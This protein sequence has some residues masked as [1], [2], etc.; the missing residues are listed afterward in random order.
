M[1]IYVWL[2]I[3]GDAVYRAEKGS[4]SGAWGIGPTA[5][6][7]RQKVAGAD[8]G[9]GDGA[10]QAFSFLPPIQSQIPDPGTGYPLLALASPYSVKPLWR[11]P[12]RQVQ[13]SVS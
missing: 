6:T 12:H 7:H 1:R 13:K 10:Q 8:A 5:P 2:I 4:S 9:A 3:W 11:S